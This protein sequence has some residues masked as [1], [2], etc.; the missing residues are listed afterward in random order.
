MGRRSW[1]EGMKVRVV[2]GDPLPE[3]EFEA[4]NELVKKV[5]L[6]ILKKKGRF[7]N[8]RVSL[9]TGLTMWHW[10]N[11]HESLN[12]ISHCYQ[13]EK[14]GNQKIPPFSIGYFQL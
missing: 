1:M 13:K 6:R 5:T 14:A 10:Q 12:S 4:L 7:Q 9:S 3:Y 11:R 8:V 2:L